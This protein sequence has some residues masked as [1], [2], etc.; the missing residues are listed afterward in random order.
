MN[1]EIK[2]TGTPNQVEWAEQIRSTVAQEFDRVAKAFTARITIQTG[3]KQAE[4]RAI[5][6]ILEQKRAETMVNPHAGY[7]IRDWQELSDQVRRMIAQ[8]PRYRAIKNQRA[9]RRRGQQ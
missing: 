9:A 3:E 2:L 4:T 7:F 8:D 6:A 5:L 1:H